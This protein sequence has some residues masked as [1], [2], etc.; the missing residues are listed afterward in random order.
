MS[1]A[2]ISRE[3]RKARKASFIDLSAR[4]LVPRD[5]C[6]NPFAPS[7]VPAKI[8]FGLARYA[9]NTIA[10]PAIAIAAPIQRRIG[11]TSPAKRE[12]TRT[13]TAPV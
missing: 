7:W 8:L 9:S 11:I 12:S 2:E 4:T 1:E 10:T 3:P 6:E 13:N 5:R